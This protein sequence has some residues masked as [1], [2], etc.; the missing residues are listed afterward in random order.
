MS[1][2]DAKKL[3]EYN[4]YFNKTWLNNKEYP[5]KMWNHFHL[6]S[7]R[8]NNHNE[9]FNN[10]LMHF[11]RI[12]HPSIFQLINDLKA[13]ESRESTEYYNLKYGFSQ[14]KKRLPI[15]VRRDTRIAKLK[16]E[17]SKYSMSLKTYMV[18][19]SRLYTY[20]KDDTDRPKV[21]SEDINHISL[22]DNYFYFFK[23]SDLHKKSAD[24]IKNYFELNQVIVT[25]LINFIS[26][27]D[28]CIF[29]NND[30]EFSVKDLVSYY[31][32]ASC[33]PLKT[34][35]DNRCLFHAISLCLYGSEKFTH[36]IKI[37]CVFTLLNNESYF[38]KVLKQQDCML[39]FEK[40]VENNGD[41]DVWGDHFSLMALSILIRRPIYT[42]SSYK[43]SCSNTN[44]FNYSSMP[45]KIILFNSH[46]SAIVPFNYFNNYG[47]VPIIK[48]EL[49]Q[50]DS[51]KSDS[52]VV[53]NID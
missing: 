22:F 44:P 51:I 52:V 41:N 35:G 4:E 10:F 20:S 37:S 26:L 16:N 12:I 2:A 18:E 30:I 39:S 27:N 8:T 45:V 23:M 21:T 28:L 47:Y 48:N 42:Y 36:L 17:L 53:I 14:P 3:N 50:R 34:S 32:S 1:V 25:R 19:T 5:R 15:N 6:F 33:V 9:G 43:N 29:D 40:L 38:K 46:F 31:S 11:V 24:Q 7:D 49:N 13:I